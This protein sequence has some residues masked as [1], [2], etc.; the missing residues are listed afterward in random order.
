VR[1]SVL[2]LA[3]LAA[4]GVAPALADGAIAAGSTGNVVRDGIA[5]GWTVNEAKEAA[6]QTAI[7]H[8]RTFEARAA[9]NRCQVVAT[10]SGECFAIAYDPKPGTPGAGWGVGS[11]QLAANQKAIAMCEESAGP[12]RKGYCRVER[13]GCDTTGQRQAPEAAP[14]DQTQAPTQSPGNSDAK[15]D[16]AASPEPPPAPQPRRQPPAEPTAR[17]TGSPLLPIGAM[18]GVG[19]AYALGQYLRGKL[20]GSIAERQVLTGGALAIGAAIAVKLL[21]MAGAE[22]TVSLVLAGLLALGAAFLF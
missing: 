8:C 9:A 11:D 12:A 14:K 10:F 22:Q 15:A 20:K 18:A 13:F 21:D 3:V 7:S 6:I 16:V 4:A 1:R 5:F 19:I 2:G 17:N